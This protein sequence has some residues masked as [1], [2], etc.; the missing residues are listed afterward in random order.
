MEHITRKGWLRDDS[1]RKDFMNGIDLLAFSSDAPGSTW[2]S[3]WESMQLQFEKHTDL[4]EY[5]RKEW[6]CDTWRIMWIGRGRRNI[7]HFL[8]NT[9]NSAELFFVSNPACW[10]RLSI[11]AHIPLSA[12]CHSFQP[13]HFLHCRII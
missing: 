8:L 7:A 5:M 2:E 4:L 13:L 3:I 9:S 10:L 11:S 12:V 6:I 1:E